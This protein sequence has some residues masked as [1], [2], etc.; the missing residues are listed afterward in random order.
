M[1]KPNANTE[2]RDWITPEQVRVVKVTPPAD[3]FER[4]L[5]K[6]RLLREQMG[7][8]YLCSEKNRVRR[9]DGKTYVRTAGTNVLP[10]K[11][12]AVG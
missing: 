8:R 9:L 10:I 2:V 3:Q 11:R 12:G 7:P 6:A 4:I 5:Q 1:F